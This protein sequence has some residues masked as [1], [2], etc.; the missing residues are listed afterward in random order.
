M[1]GGQQRLRF[2]HRASMT[3]LPFAILMVGLAAPAS[4]ADLPRYDVSG[5]CGRMAVAAGSRSAEI[6]EACERRE[7]EAHAALE[8]NWPLVS[9]P[10]RNRCLHAVRMDTGS[11][12]TLHDCVALDLAKEERRRWDSRPTVRQ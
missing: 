2:A 10:A 9:P 5:H 1:M 12:V 3:R 4:A 11:Y 6:R 8:Q 7:Q